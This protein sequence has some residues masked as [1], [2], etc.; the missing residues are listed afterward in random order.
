MDGK[1]VQEDQNRSDVVPL[2]SASQEA[3]GGVFAPSAGDGGSPDQH[4]CVKNCKKQ[5]W[6]E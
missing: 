2:L 3:S 5:V 6:R 1:P 4:Q